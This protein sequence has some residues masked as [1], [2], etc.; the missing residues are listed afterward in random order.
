MSPASRWSRNCT[1][2]TT[3]PPL[4]SRQGM[5]LRAGIERLREG[6]AALPQGL[7]DDCPGGARLP[8]AAQIVERRDAARRLQGEMGKGGCGAPYQVEIGAGEHPVARNVGDEE[9]AGGGIEARH[10]PQAAT[11]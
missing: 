9:M 8:A 5:I 10:V 4:T 2:L 7:A 11:G 3:R 1:P 6:E